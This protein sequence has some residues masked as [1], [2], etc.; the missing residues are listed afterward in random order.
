MLAADEE[1]GGAMNELL[2]DA[3]SHSAWAKK[4]LIAACEAL[5]VAEMD[6]PISGSVVA[7]VQR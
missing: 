7:F 2:L 4:K 3:F 1:K 6:R 5:S